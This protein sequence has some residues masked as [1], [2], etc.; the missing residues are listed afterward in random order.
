MRCM[1]RRLPALA[2]DEALASPRAVEWSWRNDC[3]ADAPCGDVLRAAA[4]C[5][6][7]L[8][9]APLFS[10]LAIR[11]ISGDGGLE[12]E[13]ADR[14]RGGGA[15]RDGDSSA[16]AAPPPP[17][18][19][20]VTALPAAAIAALAAAAAAQPVPAPASP[21]LWALPSVAPLARPAPCLTR[22]AAAIPPPAAAAPAKVP[23]AAPPTTPPPRG[24]TVRGDKPTRAASPAGAGAACSTAVDVAAL[25]WG[26]RR[27]AGVPHAAAHEL[28]T[29]ADTSGCWRPV[30]GATSAAARRPAALS[31]VRP[32]ALVPAPPWAPSLAAPG[33]LSFLSAERLERIA[34]SSSERS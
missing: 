4:L 24:V 2:S 6:K 23:A 1:R 31:A 12:P 14:G 32:F 18:F 21:L 30:R 19:A 5:V 13:C 11:T 33:F 17:P 22:P 25:G 7:W 10:V 3:T 20:T 15:R 9:L 8:L 27:C 16:S 29:P 34:F 28:G 26:C